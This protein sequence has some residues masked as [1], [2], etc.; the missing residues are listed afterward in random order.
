MMIDILG[1]PFLVSQ[2]G[3]MGE[4]LQTTHITV[5]TPSLL[6][7]GFFISLVLS[8]VAGLYPARRAA[9]LNPLEAL[10]QI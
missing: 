7:A 4:R 1:K 3:E 5:I 6:I 2:L 9:K 8:I 10:R